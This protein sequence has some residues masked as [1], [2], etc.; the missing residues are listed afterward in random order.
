LIASNPVSVAIADFE[1]YSA[2]QRAEH[3]QCNIESRLP[4]FGHNWK[5]AWLCRFTLVGIESRIGEQVG[6]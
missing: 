6:N 5:P 3:N 4:R 1:Q 2:R